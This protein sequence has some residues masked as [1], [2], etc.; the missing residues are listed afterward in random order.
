MS[1][2]LRTRGNRLSINN[3]GKSIPGGRNGRDTVGGAYALR[4][5]GW[6]DREVW[7]RAEEMIR[8]F[9]LILPHRIIAMCAEHLSHEDKHL[10]KG[11]VP[12]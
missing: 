5:Q 1:R 11:V 4:G 12:I 9:S 8:A 10:C 2:D 7:G 6:L 3:G